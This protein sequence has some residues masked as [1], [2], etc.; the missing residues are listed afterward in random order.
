[1]TRIVLALLALFFLAAPAAAQ[2]TVKWGAIAFG[3]PDRKTG[4]AVDLPSAGEA[5]E[6]ARE[7]CEGACPRT[8]VFYGI[9]AAVAQNES[10]GLGW[11]S[12]RWRGRAE[13]RALIVCQ[14]SGP[15][16]TI[17]RWACTVH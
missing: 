12:S 10:G 6:A 1:M 17:T 15:G 14:R 13:A 5:R 7:N 3:A 11:A 16:C 8:I 4:A 2:N 9:C